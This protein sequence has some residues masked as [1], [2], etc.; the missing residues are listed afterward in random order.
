[1]KYM[2][3]K[4]IV[5]PKEP[6]NELSERLEVKGKIGQGGMSVI[7]NAV[8]KNLLRTSAIKMIHPEMS[9]DVNTRRRMIEE[10]QITAQLDH[11]NILPVHELG[12]MSDG[13]LFF[14]M[15]VVEGKTL[16][17]ILQAQDYSRR[18]EKELFDQL[19]HFIKACDAVAFAHNHG[20]IH[21]DL[22]PDNIMIG[23][24]GEVYLM[25]WGI[26]RPKS[27]PDREEEPPEPRPGKYR[28]RSS[29]ER[30]K[31][32]GTPHYMSPEQAA[33]EHDATDERSDIFSLGAILYE[34]LTKEP[35]Y[36]GNSTIEVLVKAAERDMEP[37]QAVVNFDL[38]PR[39]CRIAM[40]AMHRNPARRYQS[41][42]E[43]K[44]EVV[45]FLQSGWQFPMQT[46][47]PSDLI[48]R[49]GERG[50]KAYII[51]SGRCQVY[52]TVEG[53]QIVLTE[54]G[55]G[56]V[57]GETAVFADEPRNAS[58][59]ALDKVSVRVVPREYFEEDMGMGIWMGLFVKALA[60]RF[61]ERNSR[62]A[63]LEE[64]QQHHQLCVQVLKYLN[65]SGAE[66]P[67]GDRQARWSPLRDAL[68][69]RFNLSA[70]AITNSVR[71][72]QTFSLDEEGD[73]ISIGRL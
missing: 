6:T 58:V 36:R 52:K 5:D 48:V 27:K 67:D 28:Y 61:N 15:K 9:L 44:Q 23:D 43:L 63:K 19:Q 32:I 72:N 31:Y 11:P 53:K 46:F 24:F 56:D 18:D 64:E 40:K 21:R 1:M 2:G 39:L 71:A 45:N 41:V 33:G 59:E 70:E 47:G 68:A 22:K 4:V 7:R 65:F 73:W 51:T 29:T 42:V 10:A 3:K 16:T 54:F 25:D 50:D 35:P 26:S 60:R 14:T 38:P 66:R 55:P 57:F 49:E 34:I 62:A 8:D 17:E 12:V 69:D 37:P 20:V 13:R 30:G